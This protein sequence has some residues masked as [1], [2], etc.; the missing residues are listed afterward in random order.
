MRAALGASS[1]AWDEIGASITAK[2]LR[3]P[4]LEAHTREYKEHRDERLR[5]LVKV[6]LPL[7]EAST[8][9]EY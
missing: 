1:A 4:E 5:Q 7:L 9:P 3:R 8:A 2:L 6:D